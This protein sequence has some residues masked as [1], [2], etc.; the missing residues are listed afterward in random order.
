[1]KPEALPQFLFG[2]DA[3]LR[4]E[5]SIQIHFTEKRQVLS[6]SP[7]NGGYRED[8][9]GV[10]NFDETPAKGRNCVMRAPTYEQHMQ[11]VAKELGFDPAHCAG[12]STAAHMKYAASVSD[13]YNGTAV[14]AIVTGGINKNGGR[15]GDPASWDERA[16]NDANRHHGTVNILLAVDSHLSEGAMTKAVI[17]ATEAKTAAI[18]ELL[19]QSFYSDGLATG[20]GTDGIMV[21]ANPQS[22]IYLTDAGQHSK[23]GELI[24]STV[25]AAVKRALYLQT[26]LGY[27]QQHNVFCRMRRFGVTEQALTEHFMEYKPSPEQFKLFRQNIKNVALQDE[28]LTYTS[29]YAHLLDQLK[30]GMLSVPEAVHAGNRLLC[31]MDMEYR[32]SDLSDNGYAEMISQYQ[33]GLFDKMVGNVLE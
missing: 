27:Q 20:T 4:F 24:G 3:V 1:M 29:L 14:T 21:I 9:S 12:L 32:I 26:G 10:F 5:K 18:Q 19:A 31:L 22:E 2:T 23:L 15:A 8:L 33:N 17:T 7:L 6:S 25:L 28:L 13:T 11:I 16:F 30:W